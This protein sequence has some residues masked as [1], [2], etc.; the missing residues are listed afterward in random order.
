MLAPAR[1]RSQGSRPS[2]GRRR[3]VARSCTLDVLP[4]ARNARPAA[5]PGGGLWPG[6]T[7]TTCR[8]AAARTSGSSSWR[9]SPGV[10]PIDCAYLVHGSSS[11]AAAAPGDVVVVE[12]ETANAAVQAVEGISQTAAARGY[13]ARTLGD[14]TSHALP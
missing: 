13:A 9:S 4:L 10:W 5:P 14:V 1:N 7:T 12:T 11:R 8:C 6:A 3:P 2:R